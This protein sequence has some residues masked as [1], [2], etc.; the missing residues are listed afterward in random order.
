MEP[1]VGST[2]QLFLENGTVMRTSV[3][4]HVERRGKELVVDT[5]NSR[6]RLVPQAA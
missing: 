5:A 2:L 3:V 4:Q 1:E 6:Y